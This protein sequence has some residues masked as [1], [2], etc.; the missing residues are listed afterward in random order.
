MWYCPMS[1][2][3]SLLIAWKNCLISFFFLF[4]VCFTFSIIL[5]CFTFSFSRLE[6]ERLF[7]RN[8]IPYILLHTKGAFRF[9]HCNL[10]NVP[11]ILPPWDRSHFFQTFTQLTFCL[12]LFCFCFH[13][14]F[15]CRLQIFRG[16]AH[17]QCQDTT[18]KQV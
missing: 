3:N 9:L 12:V 13:Q 10:K 5:V 8:G 6:D 1:M 7:W 17:S 15:V 14:Y 18:W 4:S 2:N 16:R 11:K